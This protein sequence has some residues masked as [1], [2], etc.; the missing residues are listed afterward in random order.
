M[1]SSQRQNSTNV[2][3]TFLICPA[4]WHNSGGAGRERVELR[5][6][7][8]LQHVGKHRR[9]LSNRLQP[10]RGRERRLQ[11]SPRSRCL[12]ARLHIGAEWSIG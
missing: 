1:E 11:H 12:R 5:P 4:S 8:L 2:R 7:H 6:D 9:I 3:R 10:L